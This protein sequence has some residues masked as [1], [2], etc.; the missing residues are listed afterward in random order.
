MKL[1]NIT[2][3]YFQYIVYFPE[4]DILQHTCIVI[5]TVN[6]ST[7]WGY[8]LKSHKKVCE[9]MI[10]IHF[11]LLFSTASTVFRILYLLATQCPTTNSAQHH[12]LSLLSPVSLIQLPLITYLPP[13]V[14]SLISSACWTTLHYHQPWKTVNTILCT[15]VQQNVSTVPP[16]THCS[17]M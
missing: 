1:G 17:Y 5:S 9:I 4:S 2:S 14:R 7:F 11:H 16:F 8:F 3:I 10:I 15:R 12:K 13:V 6:V